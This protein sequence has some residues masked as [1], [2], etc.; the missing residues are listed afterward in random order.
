[1]PASRVVIFVAGFITGG[2]A[3]G[4]IV[5]HARITTLNASIAGVLPNSEGSLFCVNVENRVLPIR[6]TYRETSVNAQ[7]S[8]GVSYGATLRCP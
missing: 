2:I 3:L 8:P 7:A 5:A 6:G 1:M 4:G